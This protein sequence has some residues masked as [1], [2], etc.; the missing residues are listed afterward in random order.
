M[1]IQIG[2]PETNMAVEPAH[3]QSLLSQPST[4]AAGSMKSKVK[5][6]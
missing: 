2:G 1:V 4:I 5:T 3:L 6:N